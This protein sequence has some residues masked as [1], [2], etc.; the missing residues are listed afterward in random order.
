ML[1]QG[2]QLGLDLL[3]IHPRIT[4]FVRSNESGDTGG[5]MMRI[6]ATLA[7]SLFDE[8]IAIRIL[9]PP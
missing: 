2:P 9:E 6:E 1:R 8:P 3:L 5:K 7:E 4:H